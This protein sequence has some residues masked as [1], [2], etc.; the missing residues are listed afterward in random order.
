MGLDLYLFTEPQVELEVACCWRGIA[1]DLNLPVLL[2]KKGCEFWDHVDD[3]EGEDWDFEKDE[4]VPGKEVK[5]ADPKVILRKAQEAR[6]IL[7]A[8]SDKDLLQD[9]EALLGELD[10]ILVALKETIKH[11]VKA[12]F[13]V[14]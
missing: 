2:K 1:N 7:E 14:M 3:G 6:S 12:R 5:Y 8:A 11:D 13:G 10:E 9:R 4:L